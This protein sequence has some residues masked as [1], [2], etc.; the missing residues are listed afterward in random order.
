MRLTH[1]ASFSVWLSRTV[2]WLGL[3][4]SFTAVGAPLLPGPQDAAKAATQTTEQSPAECA[5]G[6]SLNFVAHPDD[7]LL[8]MNPDLDNDIAQ[9]LCVHVVYLTAGDRGEGMGYTSARE[10]GIMA[11]YAH[12][13]GVANDWSTDGLMVGQH[14]LVRHTLNANPHIQLIMLR[15]PDPW[16]GPGWGSLTPMSQLESVPHT[17]VQSYAPYHV[18]YTRTGLVRM[19]ADLIDQEKPQAIRL[20]DP[21]ITIPYQEL[22]WKCVGHDHPDHIAGARLVVEAMKLAPGS[23]VRTT[24]LN[25]PSKERQA[26]LDTAAITRKTEIFLRYAVE[27][28]KICPTRSSCAHPKGM[29]AI[30]VGRKYYVEPVAISPRTV[31]DK[32]T[33]QARSSP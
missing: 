2:A 27:D 22:C 29:E 3:T 31:E 24:Y 33:L 16:L 19:L 9:R 11:A 12:M 1:L 21:S 20:M 5:V 8:F 4:L 25:Y 7:D 10:R 15:L 14:T 32:Q 18:T 17:Q 28:P 23:Y 13:A 6:K 26:N 30:W